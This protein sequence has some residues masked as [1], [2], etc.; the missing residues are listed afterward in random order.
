MDL[1]KIGAYIAGKRKGLGLTQRELAEKLGMSDKSVSKWERGVCLPDVSV[2]R[3]LCGILGISLN[4][5]FAGEDLDE[6]SLPERS[7]EN[8]LSVSKDG[9]SRRKK[10]KGI[11]VVLAAAALLLG[12]LLAW[13]LTADVWAEKNKIV[14]FPKDSTERKTAELLCGVDGA[15]LFRYTTDGSFREMTIWHTVYRKGE[16]VSRSPFMTSPAAEILEE[17]II[18]L[19]PD[20]DRRE[21]R[22]LL[23]GDSSKLSTALPAPEDGE[24]WEGCI[25]TAEEREAVYGL[26]DGREYILLAVSYS[27]DFLLSFNLE[28]LEPGGSGPPDNDET[29]CF[30]V[31]FSK[32]ESAA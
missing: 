12:G 24:S 21:I 29:H 7:E 25:R 22:F 19:I 27:R 18:C 20:Y 2:Y 6:Q 11:I 32:G 15:Y 13:V 23:A 17:G 16:L 9:K 3:E 28:D 26:E 5:F 8:L 1:Q 10:L 31:V 30:S 14:P 4:E